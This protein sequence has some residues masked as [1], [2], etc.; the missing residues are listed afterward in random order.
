MKHLRE[1]LLLAV[2]VI[3][4]LLT[5]V[6]VG[7]RI[8]AWLDQKYFDILFT[9]SHPPAVEHPLSLVV[10][11]QSFQ[12]RFGRDPDRRDMARIV[13]LLNRAG[14]RTAG[15]DLIYDQPQNEET[16]QILATAMSRFGGAILAQRFSSRAIQA[17]LDTITLTTGGRPPAPLALYAPISDAAFGTGIINILAGM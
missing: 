10:K 14:V 8:V 6:P 1:R 5:L 13:S 4:C 2:P 12:E 17:G 11:D 3:I 16:D 7:N 9:F 15:F